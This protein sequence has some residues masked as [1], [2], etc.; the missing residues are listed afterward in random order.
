[1]KPGPCV[2]CR[3]PCDDNRVYFG[4]V[5]PFCS[6]ECRDSCRCSSHD[7][8]GGTTTQQE[9]EAALLAEVAGQLK[10]AP[11]VISEIPAFSAFAICAALQLALRHPALIFGTLG[12]ATI[13]RATRDLQAAI[14]DRSPGAG[15]LLEQG[16]DP[17]LD[18]PVP[19]TS[20]AER[21]RRHEEFAGRVFEHVSNCERCR[22][23]A[24]KEELCP[25][26]A[27]LYG[28]ALAWAIPGPEVS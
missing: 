12:R 20:E 16:W 14:R 15:D 5:G 26:G 24:R 25:I 23:S 6:V 1:M 17:T 8:D 22:F 27:T 28:R 7:S 21:V 11:P 18:R 3:K 9:R 10:D 2:H 19:G 4:V 13:E